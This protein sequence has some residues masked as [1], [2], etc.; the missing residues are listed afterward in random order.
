MQRTNKYAY[1]TDSIVCLLFFVFNDVNNSKLC[2]SIPIWELWKFLHVCSKFNI[3]QHNSLYKDTRKL[4]K[5][6]LYSHSTDL[7]FLLKRHSGERFQN[8]R[9]ANEFL[10]VYMI[11]NVICILTLEINYIHVTCLTC[12]LHNRALLKNICISIFN[13]SCMFVFFFFFFVW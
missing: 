7:A 6:N 9:H 5:C 10:V 8:V 3:P 12:I 1:I 11:Y 13:K 2:L 4:L